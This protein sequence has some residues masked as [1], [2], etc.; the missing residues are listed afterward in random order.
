MFAGIGGICLGFK[1]AGFDVVWA[2]ELDAAAARTYRSNFSNT[3]LAE[4][5]I[6]TISAVIVPDIDVLTAGFPCQAFSTA[7]KQKGFADP[8]GNLFFEVARILDTKRPRVV[9]LENVSNLSEHDG[10]RTFLVIYNSLAQF[11]Y[12]V[13]YKVMDAQKYGDIPQKRERIFLVGFR[14]FGDCERFKFPEELQLAKGV[15]D[16]IDISQRH[17]D[18]YYYNETTEY[19]KSVQAAVK[20][21]SR[22]YRIGDGGAIRG[23]TKCPTF[24]ASM[25]DHF[26]RV[27]VIRDDFGIRRLTPAE[28]L[29]L[30]GFPKD[31]T[32]PSGVSMV[33]AYKQAGNSVCVPVI[34]RI[35][36][37][38]RTV[39]S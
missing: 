14:D 25:G 26:Y 21:K 18:C 37:N 23:C 35:A 36:E 17:S 24:V 33:D 16:L 12:Y 2:N 15:F 38:I 3:V 1:Q 34:K 20:S 31:F 22:I 29:T 5:N 6:K 39:L 30:Q 28:C 8:R 7:G 32:F 27:P 19:F 11:G 10:G 13:K 4:G 9:F